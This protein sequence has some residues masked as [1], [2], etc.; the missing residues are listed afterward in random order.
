M[1][2]HF[3]LNL[4]SWNMIRRFVCVQFGYVI[5]GAGS[6]LLALLVFPF[7]NLCSPENTRKARIRWLIQKNFAVFVEYLRITGVLQYQIRNLDKLKSGSLVLA[8][9]PSLL[10]I[11]FLFSF[12]PNANCVVKSKLLRNPF[13]RF[14]ILCAGYIVNDDPEEVVTKALQSFEAKETLIIFPEGTRTRENQPLQ[15]K[16]GACQIAVRTNKDVTPIV[17]HADP[18]GLTKEAPWFSITTKPWR[19]RFE[20]KDQLLISQ[21]YT[22]QDSLAIRARNL[23]RGLERYFNQQCQSRQQ[24]QIQSNQVQLTQRSSK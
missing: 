4:W 7:V 1:A 5:F 15:L 11:V 19:F 13:T 24:Y 6:V 17:I 20:V 12:I 3:E 23:T 21:F 14:P 9:H 8:N 16:R 2:R 10:D 18:P 22:Q